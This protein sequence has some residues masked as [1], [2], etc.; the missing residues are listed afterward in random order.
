MTSSVD[1]TV[2][3]RTEQ[4]YNTMSKA[5]YEFNKAVFNPLH[6]S[7]YN[8]TDIQILKECRTILPVGELNKF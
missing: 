7:D 5:I 1:G 2:T 8:E 3:V 4:I 6:K